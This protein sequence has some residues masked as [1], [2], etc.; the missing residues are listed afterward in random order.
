LF[1][2]AI[3]T[4]ECRTT[5]VHDGGDHSIIIGAVVTAATRHEASPLVYFEGHYR[6]LTPGA[7]PGTP[8]D[9]GP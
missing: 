9:P 6:H 1:D 8:P 7:P 4:L 3:A 5:A 2:T